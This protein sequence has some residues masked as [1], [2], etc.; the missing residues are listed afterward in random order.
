[1]IEIINLT[2]KYGRFTAVE[3]LNLV[4]NKGELFTIVGPNG[5]GKTTL[6]R[7]LCGSLKPTEGTIKVGGY[8]ITKDP[9]KAKSILGYLPE[10]PNLYERLTPGELLAFFAKLY[11]VK[12]PERRIKDL[13][14]MVGLRERMDSKIS[15]FSKGM[16]QRLMIVRSII[17]DP[18]ILV[19]DE[20]TFGLDPGTAISVRNFV[21]EQKRK[22][23]IL[24]CTHNMQEAEMLCDRIG[25]LNN[26]RLV[27]VGKPDDLKNVVKENGVENPTLDD[28]FVHFVGGG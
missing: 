21:F 1:M 9:I 24:L 15:T 7:V 13:L 3:N 26:G 25:V 18:E 12:N 4:I 14:E 8:D 11:G 5:A 6:V 17:H 22:K 23:T 16:R 19:L 20:P 10:E 2:K 27:A 28:V